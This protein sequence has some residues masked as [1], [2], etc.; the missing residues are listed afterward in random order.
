MKTKL[1]IWVA[2]L[3]IGSMSRVQAQSD[4]DVSLKSDFVSD[5][6]WRGLDLGNASIQPELSVGWKGLSLTA[7]G[8]AG[9]T[10]HKD[11]KREID[12][13]LSYETGGL[14]FGVTTGLTSMTAA[15]SIASETVRVTRSKVSSPTTS[16]R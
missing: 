7:W 10:G 16:V 8:S 12:M 3:S 2:I 6:N 9:L 13:T 15:I 1:L 5:Y 4:V 11:D 14:S